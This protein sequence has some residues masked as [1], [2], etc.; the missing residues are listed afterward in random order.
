MTVKDILSVI[1]T[2]YIDITDNSD[3][4]LFIGFQDDCPECFMNKTVDYLSYDRFNDRFVLRLE[5]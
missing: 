3:K 5:E 2:E 1:Y 4:S